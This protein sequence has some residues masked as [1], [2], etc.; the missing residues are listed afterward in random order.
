MYH[1]KQYQQIRNATSSIALHW[2]AYNVSEFGTFSLP[3][4]FPLLC[5][6]FGIQGL[7][8]CQNLSVRIYVYIDWCRDLLLTTVLQ[9]LNIT[10]TYKASHLHIKA[11]CP[12][13]YSGTSLETYLFI[14]EVLDICCYCNSTIHCGSMVDKNWPFQFP[15]LCFIIQFFQVSNS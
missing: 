8:N 13:I 3:H 9:K 2:S 12:G 6:H 10:P 1:F 4:A 14:Y 5:R 7:L 11:V 15:Y